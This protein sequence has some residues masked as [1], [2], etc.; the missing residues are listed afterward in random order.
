[1]QK[2]KQDIKR[3]FLRKG[4]QTGLAIVIVAALLL[5]TIA[6]IQYYHTRGVLE[7]NLEK[8][9]L[10]MLRSSAMRLDGNLNATVA[11]ASNQIWHAQQHLND[12]EYIESLIL[13][14]V[15][16]GKPRISGAAVAFRANYYP[17][18]GRWYEPYAY[19]QGDTVVLEQIGSADHDY[20]QMDFFKPCIKG[21]T[22]KWTL[23]Y[24]DEVGAEKEV[25]TY[26]LPIRDSN[27]EIVA[28]LGID[29]TTGWIIESLRQIQLHQS[30][31]TMVM[32]PDGDV[33]SAPADSICSPVLAKKIAAMMFDPAVKKEKKSDGWVTTFEFYDEQK[34]QS[35]RVYY[36]TKKHE[37]KWIMVRV[38]Y[39]DDVFGELAEM[40]SNIFWTTLVGLL[41]LG[42]IIQLFARNSRK[43]QD[44]LMLQQRTDH[45]LRIANGIQQAL[46]PY[47]EPSLRGI[48]DVEVEG[49]LIPAR[50]V[51]GDL[52]NVF[53][54]D[55]RLYFC[56]GDVSGKGV[57]SALIMAVM[58]T[59]FHNIASEE[60]NPARI[61]ERMNATA[62]RN[63]RSNLFVTMFIGVLDLRDGNLDYCNAGH[64]RPVLNGKPL[65]T[66][67]NMPLGLF[68]GFIYEMQRTTLVPGEPLTL[69]TDGLT[70]SL[71]EQHQLFGRKRAMQLIARCSGMS[72]KLIVDTVITEVRKY[73][74]QTEQN[75][76]LTLLSICYKPENLKMK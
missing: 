63:N 10:I 12:P 22:L 75:D 32:S 8:Q 34:D 30:S 40:Q 57:P 17:Q 31:Y 26:S 15:K 76:D 73:A 5:E 45:E 60:N 52:Y 68:D 74:G 13:D 28:V 66:I 4:R 24:M 43:L 46:L 65:E 61:M 3:Q 62:C 14:L 2:Q 47:D 41:V 71:N 54:R 27:G 56:I 25:V 59:L 11:Q 58:Q 18:K 16:N 64:E 36:A 20:F 7:R 44:T 38:A 19:W 35:G 70:E 6:A 9:V 23:P 33:I 55:G 48:S 53:V 29:V 1:M 67:P 51:G 42:L 49:C 50:E 21:D 69:Y 37:P 72:P 39:D